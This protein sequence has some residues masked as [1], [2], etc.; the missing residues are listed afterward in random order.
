M[1]E[2]TETVDNKRQ[3]EKVFM[4]LWLFLVSG[5]AVALRL[6]ARVYLG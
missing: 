5:F 3:T 1:A 4:I 2:R 6:S